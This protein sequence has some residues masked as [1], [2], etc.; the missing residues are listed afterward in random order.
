MLYQLAADA[1]LLIHLGFIL[2]VVT[3]GV[4]VW[5]WRWLAWVHLPAVGWGAMIEFGGWICPLTPLENRL[6][7]AAGAS[8]YPGG[9]IEHYLLPLIYPA[10]FT[11]ELQVFLGI[12]VVVLNAL[13]YGWLW[14]KPKK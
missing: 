12:L 5:R 1:V 6:R 10:E 2:F 8:G 14:L 9:F 4:L 13:I 3:G 11:R 7:A